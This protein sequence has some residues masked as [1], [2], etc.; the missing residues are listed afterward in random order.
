MK[1][2]LLPFFLTL[3]IIA[4]MS[5]H[6]YTRPRGDPLTASQFRAMMAKPVRQIAEEIPKGREDDEHGEVSRVPL[7]KDAQWIITVPYANSNGDTVLLNYRLYELGA[8]TE[9]VML[10]M[11]SIRRE[12]TDKGFK[13]TRTPRPDPT[14]GTNQYKLLLGGDISYSIKDKEWTRKEGNLMVLIIHKKAW[15]RTDLALDEC[16]T[17]KAVA[18]L[19]GEIMERLTPGQLI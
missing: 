3:A 17:E 9:S 18:E 2:R 10:L 19:T 4:A 11:Q 15:E 12:L 13:Y 16:L 6:A 5:Y 7:D 1:T 8:C 14:L